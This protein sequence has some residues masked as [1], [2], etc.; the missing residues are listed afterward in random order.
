MKNNTIIT[1]GDSFTFGSINHLKS[2]CDS[3]IW[4]NLL[5]NHYK[6]THKLFNNSMPGRD[7]QTII[8]NWIKLLPQLK[9]N[10][11]LIVGLPTLQRWRKPMDVNNWKTIQVDDLSLTNRFQLPEH[12]WSEGELSPKTSFNELDNYIRFLNEHESFVYNFN[13]I[14]KI[15]VVLTRCKSYVWSWSDWL[16]VDILTENISEI[17]NNIGWETSHDEYI[18]TNG[19]CGANDDLHFSSNMHH[20]FAK[21]IISKLYNI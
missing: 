12:V 21:Y 19:K 4:P 13:E 1:L 3:T 17:K 6:K 7:V 10:D 16:D 8:D 15:L 18:K 20:K 14:I 9:E 5:A 2:D 11:I